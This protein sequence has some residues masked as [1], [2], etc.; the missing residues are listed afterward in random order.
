MERGNEWS[1]YE[2]NARAG[3]FQNVCDTSCT[4]KV[5]RRRLV[6]KPHST[7]IQHL[8][9][10]AITRSG[11]MAMDG[12]ILLVGGPTSRMDRMA[13]VPLSFPARRAECVGRTKDSR[14]T[15]SSIKL[16]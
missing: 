13:A 11:R 3:A 16:L 1:K 8:L 5:N 12:D 4:D 9:F 7:M 15:E 2:R 10:A 6:F 14:L